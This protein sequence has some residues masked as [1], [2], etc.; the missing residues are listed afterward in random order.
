MPRDRSSTSDSRLLSGEVPMDVR[1]LEDER[2]M[3]GGV[4]KA[5]PECGWAG[6]CSVQEAVA[7]AEGVEG[8]IRMRESAKVYSSRRG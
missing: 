8:A 1:L 7:K 4:W 2:G 5:V 6:T 3:R